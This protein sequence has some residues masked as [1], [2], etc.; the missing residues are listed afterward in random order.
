MPSR[1]APIV[2]AGAA[3]ADTLREFPWV[4]HE[5][6]TEYVYRLNAI[7][8][9]GVEED[10][11]DA[12]AIVEFGADGEWVGLLPNSPSRLDV[13]AAA[14][15]RFMLRWTYA[16]AGQ[17]AAPT[18]FRVFTDG[19]TGLVDYVTPAGVV[20]YRPRRLFYEYVSEPW[21]HNAKVRWAV[22]AYTIADA[23]DTNTNE[24]YAWADADGPPGLEALAVEAIAESSA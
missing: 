24:V 14:G 6:D 17:Q 8:R 9:G 21:P 7:G 12:V 23:H 3:G 22:R 13:R 5:P 18:Q 4:Q 15:G 10:S 2:G 19:G 1:T 16:E 20:A 11:A